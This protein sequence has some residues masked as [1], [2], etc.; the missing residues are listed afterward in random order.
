MIV[1]GLLRESVDASG[2]DP[3]K[4]FKDIANE[5]TS[6]NLAALPR[7]QELADRI[8][9]YAELIEAAKE[10]GD[11]NAVIEYLTKMF[12][13]NSDYVDLKNSARFYDYSPGNA[14]LLAIQKAP[15]Q[16]LGTADWW[17]KQGR[18][19]KRHGKFKVILRPILTTDA[20]DLTLSVKTEI[21]KSYPFGALKPKIKNEIIS[22]NPDIDQTREYKGYEYYNLATSAPIDTNIMPRLADRQFRNEVS[23]FLLMAFGLKPSDKSQ[24]YKTGYLYSFDQTEP[25]ENAQRHPETAQALNITEEQLDDA[26]GVAS[27]IVDGLVEMDANEAELEATTD[28]TGVALF[29]DVIDHMESIMKQE[30]DDD[31]NM[32][33]LNSL[34]ELNDRI[35]TLRQYLSSYEYTTRNLLFLAMQS[36]NITEIGPRSYWFIQN[37][38]PRTDATGLVILKPITE[39]NPLE[40]ANHVINIPV[41]LS[42]IKNYRLKKRFVDELGL[43]FDEETQHTVGE[44]FLAANNLPA[45]TVIQGMPAWDFQLSRFY[46]ELTGLKTQIAKGYH[47]AIVY[48]ISDVEQMPNTEVVDRLITPAVQDISYDGNIEQLKDILKAANSMLNE[49]RQ[50]PE[51]SVSKGGRSI[52]SAKCL[53]PATFDPKY[54][55]PGSL[56]GTDPLASK[57]FDLLRIDKSASPIIQQ[58]ARIIHLIVHEV[59][60]YNRGVLSKNYIGE[61]KSQADLIYYH[62]F[63]LKPGVRLFH[64]PVDLSATRTF[65]NQHGREVTTTAKEFRGLTTG[66]GEANRY[67]RE[68]QAEIITAMVM[69]TLNIPTQLVGSNLALLST[70]SGDKDIDNTPANEVQY[71]VDVTNV[72]LQK[73]REKMHGVNEQCNSIKTLVEQ[74]LI[75]RNLLK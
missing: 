1:E 63:D 26:M 49:L 59:S 64:N 45:D 31:A 6:S 67:M 62:Y 36:D 44:L 11:E 66:Q 42:Q 60:H 32:A 46:I 23:Q 57:K 37:K 52:V 40:I 50:N 38:Q 12:Q 75:N 72:I 58:I 21:Q 2:I 13:F 33:F 3:Y 73:L 29:H 51:L 28:E 7:A 56:K 20:N 14:A 61:P 55:V 34:L 25:I 19:V 68:T 69:R 35:N 4:L 10:S 30:G 16:I 43:V 47:I 39:Q 27:E 22:K 5:I 18:K 17:K 15:A 54:V 70:I 74:I 24:G 9:R 41:G 71:Y 8:N 65:T 53:Y 48:D